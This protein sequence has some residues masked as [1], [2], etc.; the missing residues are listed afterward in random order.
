MLVLVIAAAMATTS[1]TH[2]DTQT[3]PPESY[4]KEVVND[5]EELPESI[6]YFPGVDS[7]VTCTVDEGCGYNA[8]KAIHVVCNAAGNIAFDSK[9][10]FNAAEFETSAGDG[11][12]FW[13]AT[14]K[15]LGISLA[16]GSKNYNGRY[17]LGDGVQVMDST[18]QML[19]SSQY[20]SKAFNGQRTIGLPPGF[21]GWIMIPNKISKDGTTGG[22]WA[23]DAI[24]DNLNT[25]N[26]LMIWTGGGDFC[27]D[28]LC[29]YQQKPATAA[30]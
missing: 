30:K 11:I 3:A 12:M 2:A 16:A 21:E 25:I 8:S 10:W 19:E 7:G 28:H 15:P 4:I 18:G 29:V 17:N 14:P 5:S 26:G 20:L 1:N 13:I 27:I 24:D 6:P 9:T 22:W 23:G